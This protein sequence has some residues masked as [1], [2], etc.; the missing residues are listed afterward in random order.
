MVINDKHFYL[1]QMFLQLLKVFPIDISKKLWASHHTI[2]N[3]KIRF[4]QHI[5]INL[6]WSFVAFCLLLW[7]CVCSIDTS[8][9]HPHHVSKQSQKEMNNLVFLFVHIHPHMWGDDN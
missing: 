9:H 2:G 3:D 5:W 8:H 6:L 4:D 1:L 7:I